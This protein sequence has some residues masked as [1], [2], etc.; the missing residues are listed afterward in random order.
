MH[1]IREKCRF[2]QRLMVTYLVAYYT[3]NYCTIQYTV[4]T[5]LHCEFHVRQT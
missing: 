4:L 3:V 2:C 5:V 1:E